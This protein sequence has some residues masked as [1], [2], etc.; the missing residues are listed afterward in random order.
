MI[1]ILHKKSILI[2]IIFLISASYPI[3]YS[4]SNLSEMLEK[5]QNNLLELNYYDADIIIPDHYQ[6]IQEGI[7]QANSNSKIFVRSGIY[8][9]NIEIEKEGLFLQGE[10]K[11]NTVIDAG[12]TEMDGIIISAPNVIL[13]GFTI[14]NAK[15]DGNLIWD[16][17]GIKIYSSNVSINENIVT[18]N[19]LGITVYT[20]VFN[21]TISNNMFINDGLFIGNYLDNFKLPIESMLHTILNNTVNG[22]PLY[23]YKNQND[24]I[25]PNDAG[26]IILVNCSNAIVEDVYLSHTDFSIILGFC[27]H[28]IIQNSTVFDT[29]GE[30]ILFYSDNNIIRNITASNNLHGVCFDIGSRNN[31]A[32]YNSFSNC[33]AGI[34]IV[35][36]VDYSI[37]SPPANNIIHHNK[38]FSNSAGVDIYNRNNNI[39]KENKIYDNIAG[40]KLVYSSTENIIEKNSITSNKY[41]LHFKYFTHNNIIKQ[42]TLKRNDIS[43]IFK[44]CSKN[45][46]YNNYWNRP[47]ILPKPIFGSKTIGKIRVLQINFDRNPALQPTV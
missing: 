4:D 13:Q 8:K 12:K 34:S 41:G 17:S 1:K 27:S 45:T 6:T 19:R 3:V 10:N 25:V 42:N 31:I 18:E 47:R 22:K 44:D 46:W 36:Y 2:L 35:S 43:A 5:N 28:C 26:Q 16:Q 29:D 11:F 40:V 23:Y 33:F 15:N 39:I 32:E 7:N 24:F 9:E 30:L 38:I 20:S 14:I 21:L 37:K